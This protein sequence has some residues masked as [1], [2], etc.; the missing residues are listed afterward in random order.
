M[1]G[2]VICGRFDPAMP[3]FTAKG[4]FWSNGTTKMLARYTDEDR[5]ARTRNRCNG[6]GYE[7]VALFR[8]RT[9]DETLGL[10][11]LNDHSEGRF[12]PELIDFIE[13]DRPRRDCVKARNA[14]G[15]FTRMPR[16]RIF[17]SPRTVVFEDAIAARESCW[18]TLKKN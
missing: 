17:Q 11:Q 16:M 15:T 4:N 14:T 9:G 12:T 1:C 6:E 3:F 18:D 10:L 8:L 13:N 5:Q 7:S 2:N